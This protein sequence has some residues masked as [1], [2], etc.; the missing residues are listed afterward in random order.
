MKYCF[1]LDNTL[2]LTNNADY[3]NSKPITNAIEKVNELYKKG[4]KII[5]FTARGMGRTDGNIT[6][7]Y[8]MYFELTKK[9]LKEWQI[10]YHKLYLGKPEYDILIDDKSYNYKNNWIKKI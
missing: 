8:K 6:Q 1:D 3:Q 9:Q 2:C 4:N 7:A 10:N 5:I